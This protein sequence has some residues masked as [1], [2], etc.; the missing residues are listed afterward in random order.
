MCGGTCTIKYLNCGTEF[1]HLKVVFFI[2]QTSKR[3]KE[4]LFGRTDGNIKVN[5][6]KNILDTKINTSTLLRPGDYVIV[7]VRSHRPLVLQ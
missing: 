2:I 4:E 6:P 1:V 7:K 3:S 5:F